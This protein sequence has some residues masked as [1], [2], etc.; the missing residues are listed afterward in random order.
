[1]WDNDKWLRPALFFIPLVFSVFVY[2]GT[3][4]LFGNHYD[5]SYITYRYA[6]NLAEHGEMV[7]NVGERVDS[8]SSFL[9]TA[10][11][12]A[13]YAMG[14]RN[15][16]FVSYLLNMAALGVIALFVMLAAAR[17]SGNRWAAYTLGII[18]SCHGY[19]SGW[20]AL[21]MDT[22][23]FAALLV[24]WVYWTFARR[25][26][27][28]S[29]ALV[30]VLALCRFEGLL[31]APVWWFATGRDWRKG[32]AVLGF[33]G[34][35][36][37]GRY[38]YYGTVFPHSYLFKAITEYYRANPGNIL[39]IWKHFAFAAPFMALAGVILDRK[40]LWLGA[41]IALSAA[42][43]LA[44]PHSDWARYTVHL[45]PLM[46]IAGAPALKRW[47]VVA[48]MCAVLIWQGYGSVVW[49]RDKAA[50]LAPAQEMR[51][52]LGD[53]LA[54]NAGNEWVLSGDIG[55]I[56][57]RAKDCRFIDSFGLVS[58]DVLK[59]SAAKV[60]EEKQPK[61]I[62]DTFGIVNGEAIYTHVEGLKYTPVVAGKYTSTIMMAVAEI[63]YG[64]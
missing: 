37:L 12:A 1:M 22:V 54:K 51:G 27:W 50:E 52:Q 3:G 47:Y 38:G 31:V 17:L 18:A 5:D 63:N 28:A 20:A 15:L 58:K 61:Y 9:F 21:G 48:V 10:I 4:S 40:L 53:W 36:H 23:F 62:A 60:I 29:M 43:C 14:I 39:N 55:Q 57:Y 35:Y 33:A 45:F 8:A 30:V 16:E 42:S 2:T 7:F 24:M 34:L 49:M 19:L 44:G 59:T 46:L 26:E 11:L 13:A 41:Y 6:A 25:N 56:A 32:I 64:T